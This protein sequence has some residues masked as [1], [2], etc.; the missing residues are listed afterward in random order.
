MLAISFFFLKIFSLS[1]FLFFSVKEKAQFVALYTLF[2]ER[3]DILQVFNNNL[4]FKFTIDWP[5]CFGGRDGRVLAIF[6]NI[7][8]SRV[9]LDTS[10]KILA[11][12][13]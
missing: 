7:F 3:A 4:K 10:Q 13:Y 12:S 11:P 2:S 6:E 5:S 9:C 1:L 8:W